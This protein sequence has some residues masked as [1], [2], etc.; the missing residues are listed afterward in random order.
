MELNRLLEIT[1]DREQCEFCP[2]IDNVEMCLSCDK[3]KPITV[4]ELQEYYREIKK[5]LT[6]NASLREKLEQEYVG[7]A[8]YVIYEIMKESDIPGSQAIRDSGGTIDMMCADVANKIR[9]ELEESAYLKSQNSKLHS[10]V[11]AA[12]NDMQRLVVF[13]AD[14]CEICAGLG[15]C[16]MCHFQW[17]GVEE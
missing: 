1:N 4:K 2:D 11:E 3:V 7:G 14:P 9:A 16:D 17:R 6:E 15:N 12:V 13:S 5:M 10:E 8:K